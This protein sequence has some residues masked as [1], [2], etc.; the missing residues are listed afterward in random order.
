VEKY[1]FNPFAEI[2]IRHASTNSGANIID[3][4]NNYIG[5]GISTTLDAEKN[6]DARFSYNDYAKDAQNLM[7]EIIKKW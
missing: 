1:N 6:T 3:T 2:G 7:I 5:V 4:T